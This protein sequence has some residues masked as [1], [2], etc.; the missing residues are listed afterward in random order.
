VVLS[1]DP[2]GRA[3][4][5]AAWWDDFWR[6]PQSAR[7]RA[8]TCR[9]T[10][11][12]ALE[13]LRGEPHRHA[14]RSELPSR[15]RVL[16]LGCGDGEITEL[17][18]ADP[19]LDVVALDLSAEALVQ[20][21]S[22]RTASA[23]DRLRSVRGSAYE[24]PFRDRAFDAVVSFGYASAASYDDVE[25]EVARVL[26]PNGIAVVDFANPSLYHWVADARGTLRWY[27]RFRSS[28]D[29]QYHFGRRGLARHFRPAGLVLEAVRY[30][31]AYPPVGLLTRLPCV[32]LIDRALSRVLGPLLGRVLLAKLRRDRDEQVSL[33]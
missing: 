23:R 17:L 11:E 32:D 5:T 2:T 19:R 33:E 9:R 10:A 14:G 20:L 24:L 22:R 4:K 15:V 21:R 12:Q 27:R 16:D 13:L 25:R 1:P 28:A 30:V 29:A 8:V 6:R 18:L 7:G 26:R 3:R 31:N